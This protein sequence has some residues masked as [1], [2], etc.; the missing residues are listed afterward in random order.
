MAT[1]TITELWRYPV[2]SM[3]GEQIPD[4]EVTEAGLAGDRR[5]AVVDAETGKVGSAKHP[6]LWGRLLECEA[7][8]VSPPAGAEPAPV[9]IALPDG[10]E[11]GSHDPDVDA[12][13]TT[14]LGRAVRLTTVAPEGNSYLAVWPDDVMPDEYLS[15]VKVAGEEAEGTLTALT[16]AVAAPAGTFF[17]V[18]ALHLA[19]R[20]TL[21]HLEESH[22]SGRFDVARFR[23]NVVLDGGTAPFAENDWT[24]TTVQLGAE[25]NATVIIPTMR[26]IMITLPQGDLPRDNAIL[27]TVSTLNRIEI[28]GLGRW[29]CVGAYAGVA[30]GGRVAV[31]DDW[32]AQAL[33][34]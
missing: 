25:V 6:R 12:K 3:R 9:A 8:Y 10:T 24:G 31:G 19:T 22:P 7:R 34:A 27:R 23:P 11:T 13:L 16:N 1:G 2:K 30:A 28:Q 5:Y 29:S 17:D 4:S 15:Q 33:S 32:S 21:R 20:A 26:C 18:A 14:L